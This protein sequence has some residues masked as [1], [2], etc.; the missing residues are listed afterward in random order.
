MTTLCPRWAKQLC[1]TVTDGD[2]EHRQALGKS[3]LEPKSS[4]SHVG[5]FLPHHV[6]SLNRCFL[7]ICGLKPTN[8]SNKCWTGEITRPCRYKGRVETL[9]EAVC[10]SQPRGAGQQSAADQPADAHSFPALPLRACSPSSP[11]LGH[12]EGPELDQFHSLGLWFWGQSPEMET[13]VAQSLLQGGEGGQP[14]LGDSFCTCG[15][16][17]TVASLTAK[18]NRKSNP[19]MNTSSHSKKGRRGVGPLRRRS[20]GTNSAKFSVEWW[21]LI[22]S[23]KLLIYFSLKPDV[24]KLEARIIPSLEPASWMSVYIHWLWRWLFECFLYCLLYKNLVF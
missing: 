8:A 14:S 12:G 1:P 17:S 10:G 3:D 21:K 5:L 4:N 11:A 19:R 22:I 18:E 13:P 20:P 7:S 15:P 6:A 9:T 16:D 23:Q 24:T 2:T